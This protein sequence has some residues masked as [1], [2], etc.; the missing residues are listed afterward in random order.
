MEVAILLVLIFFNGFLALS[1]IAVVSSRP[2]RLQH[3]ADDGNTAAKT[4]LE[5]SASPGRFLS[6]VQV[7]ITLIG[8]LSGAFGSAAIAGD[9][10]A[11]IEKVDGLAAYSETIAIVVIVALTTYLSL[12]IGELVPKQLAIKNPEKFALLVAPPMKTLSWISTPAVNLLSLSSDFV[13]RLMGADAHQQDPVT[14]AEV[15]AMIEQG[16]ASGVFEVS[17][18][19]IIENVLGLADQ[20]V[21]EAMTFRTDIVWLEA[22]APFEDIQRTIIENTYAFYPVCKG[23][24]ENILGV[25]RAKD[26]LVHLLSKQPFDLKSIMQPPL[27]VPESNRIAKVLAL[28]KTSRTEIAFVIGEFGGIEGLVTMDDL[29]QEVFGDI[30]DI[31]DPEAVQRADGS[32]LL[33]GTLPFDELED[34]L[35]EINLPDPKERD[36]ETLAGFILT[37]LGRIPEAADFFEWQGLR[38]EVVDMDGRRIDKVLVSYKP[39]E[40]PPSAAS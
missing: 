24:V 10:S 17:E 14:E 32:W 29:I 31:D 37:Q 11:Q 4:A 40:T 30:D 1:E 2:T 20:R 16:I 38:F 15:L 21:T 27:Y 34:V 26:L 36:Y 19:E 33:D 5:L 18:H 23:S 3:L 25:V 39:S 13:L 9:L 35:P 6:T 8:V 12:I 22:E 28:F 7:G